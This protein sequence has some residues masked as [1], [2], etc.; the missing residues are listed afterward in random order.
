MAVVAALRSGTTTDTPEA[1]TEA[2]TGVFL[3]QEAVTFPGAAVVCSA[4]LGAINLFV[5]GAAS[6]ARWVLGVCGL[7]GSV[8]TYMGCQRPEARALKAGTCLS[9]WRTQRCC[10]RVSWVSA[11]LQQVT[12]PTWGTDARSSDCT[13]TFARSLRSAQG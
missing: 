12:S 2:K 6:D 7:V 1:K 4:L 9:A 3:S 10:S 5:S 11:Q 13:G 8:I